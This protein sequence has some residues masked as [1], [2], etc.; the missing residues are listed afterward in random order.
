MEIYNKI[1]NKIKASLPFICLVITII[2]L[3]YPLIGN[4]VSYGH[5]YLFHATNNILNYTNIDVFKLNMLLPKI[6]GGTIANGF[7]YGTGIFYPPMTYYLTSYITFIFNLSYQNCVLSLTYLEILIIIASGL[8]MYKFTK[9]ISKDNHVAAISSITYISYSYFLCNIYTR[10]ALGES[11]IAVFLPLVFYGLYELFNN[12]DKKF[13]LLFII[14]YIGMIH[15]H[16]VISLF[17]TI[18][19]LIIFIINYKK[20][21]KKDIIIKLSIASILILLISSPYLVPLLEHKIYGNYTVFEKN[22][23]YQDSQIIEYT[24]S[25]SDYLLVKYKTQNGIELYFSFVTLVTTI[26]TII[27]NKKIFKKANKKIYFN[28]LLLIIIS[29]IISSKIFP[30]EKMPYFIK[31]IQFPW[32]LCILTSFGISILSGY[33]IKLIDKKYQKIIACLIIVLIIFFG[34]ATIPRENLTTVFH[35]SKMHMGNQYEYLPINTKNNLSYFNS[36]NQDIIIKEG[37]ANINITKN[38]TP[39]LKSEIALI[40]NSIKVELP[41]LYYLGYEIIMKDE[42]GNKNAIKYY[43]NEFGFIE[44]ELTK[45][46]ILEVNYKGTLASKI[47][48]YICIIAIITWI[49]VIIYIKYQDKIHIK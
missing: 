47:S 45:S 35:P 14:G 29:V 18:I 23:M 44:L 46:G 7:G 25:L 3:I 30:W 32:R 22:T 28:T 12:N 26:L 27:Y 13:Y 10:N 41:R 37:N 31:I 21:F 17:I 36:R 9:R 42:K 1:K 33:F 20:V 49:S 6:F 24:L 2:I 11:L 43:E 38:N 40:S 48:N 34:Y 4:K 16:L 39:Y 8:V 19:I 5:D 15:S